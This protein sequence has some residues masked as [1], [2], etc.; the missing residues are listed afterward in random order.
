ML[1]LSLLLLVTSGFFTYLAVS[2]GLAVAGGGGG[3]CHA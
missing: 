1:R 2:P 3:G